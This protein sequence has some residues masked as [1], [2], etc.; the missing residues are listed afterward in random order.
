MELKY[1]LYSKYWRNR[2]DWRDYEDSLLYILNRFHMITLIEVTADDF[3]IYIN[4]RRNEIKNKIVKA[5][6]RA[7]ANDE[8]F[9]PF[10]VYAYGSHRLIVEKK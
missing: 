4:T 9:I 2:V 1:H 6:G 7:M 5:L 8:D 10:V 3:T